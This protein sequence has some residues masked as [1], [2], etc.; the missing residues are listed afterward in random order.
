MK[1]LTSLVSAIVLSAGMAGSAGAELI[2]GWDF[3]QLAADGAAMGTLSAN[4]AS[5]GTSGTATPS[6]T[7]VA[8]ALPPGTNPTDAPGIQG[9]VDG[10]LEE[11]GDISF[12][13]FGVLKAA[14]QANTEYLGVTAGG[15]ASI[16][17]EATSSIP[18]SSWR[19]SF[20]GRAIPQPANPS[21]VGFTNVDVAF[22]PDCGSASSVGTVSLA[23][24]DDEYAF[25]VSGADTLS[26]GCLVLDVDGT[27]D[28]P[29]IDNVAVTALTVP[30][31]GVTSL[32]AAGALGLLGLSRRRQA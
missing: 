24:Q 3:S 10:P 1:K 21:S 16:E 11:P 20:G 9:G 13:S 30:E 12:N 5:T 15:L 2:A 14:G 27:D 18:R 6:G 4:Y 22:G 28:Q 31:P 23:S 17:F 19:V 25:F 8:S 7:V 29:L 32:L 26:T